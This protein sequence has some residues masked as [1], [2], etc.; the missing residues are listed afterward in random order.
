MGHIDKFH[1]P[2]K[3]QA[4]L[5]SGNSS[6]PIILKKVRIIFMPLYSVP[7][8]GFPR[9]FL[10]YEQPFGF[11]AMKFAIGTQVL[12]EFTLPPYFNFAC[13]TALRICM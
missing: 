3:E 1:K 12:F 13:S 7:R 6:I 10:K 5:V 8:A 9:I 4:V 2:R 11:L